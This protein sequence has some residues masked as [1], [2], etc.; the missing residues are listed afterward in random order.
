VPLFLKRA[1]LFIFVLGLSLAAP[2]QLLQQLTNTK[3][4]TAQPSPDPLGRDTP[5]G[6]VF[7]FL[8]NTQAHNYSVA[9]QYLQLPASKRQAQG[10]ELATQLKDVLDQSYEGSVR[11]ISNLPD[12]NP[13]DGVAPDRQELGMLTAGDLEANLTLVRVNDANGKKIWLFS[14]ETMAKVPD[15]YSQLEVHQVET[16]LPSFLITHQLAG[17]VIWQWLS[18][19][20]AIPASMIVGWLLV[21]LIRFPRVLWLRYRKRPK[22][23]IWAAIDTPLWLSLSV[24]IHS[25]IITRLHLPLLPR[26]YYSIVAGVMF[27][28]AAS[29]LLW[30][31]LQQ[32]LRKLRQRAIYA[33][34]AGTGSLMLLGERIL[35]AVIFVI[36]IFAMLSA[37]GFNTSTALAGVGIGGIAIAFAAQKTL[38]NLFGGISVLGDEVIRVG[39]VLRIGDRTGTVEDISLRSTRLRTVERT[40][41]AIPNGTLATINIENLTRRDKMLFTTKI[42]LRS[43]TTADHLRYVLAQ[44]RKLLY[45]H[46]KVET[47]GARVRFV[48]FD[49]SALTFEIFCYILTRDAAEFMAVQED[50][51]LW[52]MD[53]VESSGTGMAYPSQ[54][55]YLG[56][57]S[58]LDNEKAAAAKQKVQEWRDSGKMPFP[59]FASKDISEISN[60]LPYPRP[61]ASVRNTKLGD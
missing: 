59:D 7:G 33:G 15:L 3:P 41:L 25:V 61:E 2:A 44:V 54:T 1:L 12:G 37:L 30:R 5:S 9:A 40:E 36:A 48:A 56:K 47:Q 52:I 35:K 19:L 13:Q 46:P 57:D 49:S 38:E 26:H 23:A 60:S 28:A 8:Q 17:L 58:G 31:I 50:L 11:R 53:I 55:L 18:I 29:W 4:A 39:D 22:A 34:R 16:R 42:G 24:W 27:I 10:E 45:E 51:L 6:T 20:L 43:E 14:A 21:R 32:I